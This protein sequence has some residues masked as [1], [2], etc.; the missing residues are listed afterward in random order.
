MYLVPGAVAGVV[1][2]LL[3]ISLSWVLGRWSA[4][5]L[6][7]SAHPQ[8]I[9]F[10]L[11]VVAFHVLLGVRDDGGNWATA[12]QTAGFLLAGCLLTTITAL[13]DRRRRRLSAVSRG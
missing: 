13:N 9:C 4:K 8:L 1:V 5:R 7:L 6:R 2:H 3:L 11:M 10:C 12:F